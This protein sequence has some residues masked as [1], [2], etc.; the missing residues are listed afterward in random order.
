MSDRTLKRLFGLL[1]L[2]FVLYAALSWVTR[3]RRSG[4]NDD[5][6]VARLLER[7]D[8]ESVSSIQFVGSGDTVTVSRTERGWTVNEYAADSALVARFLT[9]LAESEVDAVVA[10]NPSNHERMGVEGSDAVTMRLLS[11][12]GD[13]ELILGNSGRRFGTVFAREPDADAVVSILGDLRSAAVRPVEQWRDKSVVRVDTAQVATLVFETASGSYQVERDDSAW[14]LE[15]APADSAT[16]RVV[17]SELVNV[18][19]TGFAP[20]TARLQEGQATTVTALDAAGDTLASLT[21]QSTES[22]LW[23]QRRGSPTVYELAAWREERL[24]PPRDA[25]TGEG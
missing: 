20:D 12:D 13:V 1:V 8:P 3:A 19:A 16:V 14:S 23:L 10:T 7:A 25:L 9:S 15:G 18:F 24:Y 17:L 21:A 22:G 5:S 2:G 6:G 11:D 4:S